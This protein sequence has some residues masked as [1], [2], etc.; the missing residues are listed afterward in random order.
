[1]AAPVLP[2][3]E[4]L[5]AY[6]R[7]REQRTYAWAEENIAIA[8]N[9]KQD[10]DSEGRLVKE[11]VL[12]SKLRIETRQWTMQRLDHRQWGEKKQVEVEASVQARVE[13]MTLEQRQALVDGMLKRLKIIARPAIERKRLEAQQAKPID[14]TP[15]PEPAPVAAPKKGAIGR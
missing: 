6:E 3:P 1:M 15:K 10:F 9:A 14:V 4:F 11:H 13:N 2:L 12:R 7:A 8:D 5:D